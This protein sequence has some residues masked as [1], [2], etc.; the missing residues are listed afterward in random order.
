MVSAQLKHSRKVRTLHENMNN[1]EIAR[2]LDMSEFLVKEYI[3]IIDEFN[4]KEDKVN[5]G[6]S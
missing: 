6:S 2:T 1:Q 4:K 3:S 5:D